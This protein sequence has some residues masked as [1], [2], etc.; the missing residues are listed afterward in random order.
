MLK[1][2]TNRISDP[3]LGIFSVTF[4][5][6]N[7]RILLILFF[8]SKTMIERISFIDENYLQKTNSIIDI[9]V[10][11]FIISLIWF[12][13][14]PKIKAKIIEYD[15]KQKIIQN[16]L[17]IDL[18]DEFI[19]KPESL[20]NAEY[21]IQF[22]A[23]IPH[24]YTSIHNFEENSSDEYR[25]LRYSGIE[26]GQWLK[27]DNN[28]VY[29]AKAKRENSIYSNAICIKKLNEDYFV[30]QFNGNI[31]SHF[32][33]GIENINPIESDKLYLSSQDGK[34]TRNFPKNLKNQKL[35]E[36]KKWK[37]T[38]YLQLTFSKF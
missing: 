4:V 18:N 30:A 8:D 37:D 3:F 11:P 19:N 20:Q 6:W 1:T 14:F 36:W 34:S 22:K 17:A 23:I 35:G 2:I 16:K 33:N 10:F 27:V 26:L 21:A 25:I 13:I 29:L 7:W 15:E 24:F 5:L 12:L 9:F 28:R 31:P 32:F 38:Y